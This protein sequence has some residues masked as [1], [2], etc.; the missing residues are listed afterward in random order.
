MQFGRIH[1]LALI[2]LGVI[3]I[4]FQF[5]LALSDKRD[6][7]SEPGAAV[8][9]RSNNFGPLAGIFGGVSLVAGIAVFATARR[10]DDPD[11]HHAVH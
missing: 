11:A 9:T 2:I 7:S 5:N 6:V 8:Q 10:R 1:G 3:L 4:G